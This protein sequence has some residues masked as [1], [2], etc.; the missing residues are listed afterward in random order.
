MAVGTVV[1]FWSV[2]FLFVLTPGADWAYAITAG[3]R[4]RSVVPAVGGLLSGHLAMTAVVA[5]GV[6]ALVARS[7]IVLTALTAAGAVYLVWLGITMLAKPSAPPQAGVGQ[8]P[9]SWVRQ[10]VT[11]LGISALNPKVFLLFLAL[12]PQFVDAGARWPMAVQIGVLGL[13]HV[14]SCAVVYVGVGTGARVVLRAR[15]AAARVVTWVS[16]AAMI[17]IGAFLLIERFT[18]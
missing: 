9:Q 14:A 6:A 2:S 8:S 1:A 5:A 15:P 17:G 12:L 11:G 7:P 3:V 10:A 18:G 16:G 13:V 4:H